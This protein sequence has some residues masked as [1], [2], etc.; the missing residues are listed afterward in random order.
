MLKPFFRYYGGKFRAA[1]KYP[2][3]VFDT[4]VEPFAGAAGY[5][6]R[7]P[8][9]KV[10]LVEKYPVIAEIWRY[11][12]SVTEQEIRS[13]PLDP[14]HVDEMP[15]WVPKPAKDL[16]G[17]WFN[18]AT[19]S[20]CK[21][22]SAGRVFLAANGRKMEGWTQ[23]TQERIAS[24]IQHIRHW[25]VIDGDYTQSPDIKATWFVD[26]PYNNKAGSYYK[27]GPSGLD[28]TKLADWC[29]RKQGQVMVCENGGADWLPFKP[30]AT[31]KA[32]ICRN[33]NTSGSR[34]VLWCN[35]CEP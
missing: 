19:A 6:T 28:Y 3:P 13:I 14:K 27:H 12:I 11:L 34:E 1:P 31:L 29:Q 5:A 10:I 21:S 25:Q 22:L 15:A 18:N 30:F 26:P 4:I 24:Q 2:A 16:I 35:K 8:H 23:S 20:P 32:G 33:G 17:F 9:K 7:Y